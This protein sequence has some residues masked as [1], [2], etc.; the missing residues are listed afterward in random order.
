MLALFSAHP[1][2]RDAL[3]RLTRRLRS[4]TVLATLTATLAVALVGASSQ[5][6]AHAPAGPS[7]TTPI[8]GPSAHRAPSSLEVGT[9]RLGYRKFG[10]MEVGVMTHG[11]MLPDSMGRG[12]M[13]FGKYKP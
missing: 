8:H 2:G 1:N 9:M 11:R 10:R 13:P 7:R 6:S 5:A 3:D 12:T 4:V